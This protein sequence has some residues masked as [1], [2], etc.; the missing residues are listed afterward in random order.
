MINPF[1]KLFVLILILSSCNEGNFIIETTPDIGLLESNT[2]SL[3][4]Q[5][6]NTE[7]IVLFNPPSVSLACADVPAILIPK[8]NQ[9]ENIELI[10][11]K[12]A[13]YDVPIEL[14]AIKWVVNGETALQLTDRLVLPYEL[15]ERY[16]FEIVAIL[17]NDQQLSY[18]FTL[19]VMP[20]LL[21]DEH[22]YIH[23]QSCP[24]CLTFIS[25]CTNN[26]PEQ[27]SP[28]WLICPGLL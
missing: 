23:Y 4:Q 12:V 9:G 11:A 21:L 28:I 18:N 15:N 13:E 24:L 8:I 1:T 25:C 17:K 27:S 26:F 6:N 19:K 10:F 16:D 5:A 7:R 2:A 14:K 22:G 3:N 20:D